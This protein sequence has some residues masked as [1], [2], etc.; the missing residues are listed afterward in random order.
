MRKFLCVFAL[1]CCTGVALASEKPANTNAFLTPTEDKSMVE[2]GTCSF[3]CG[4]NTYSTEAGSL[5]QC[6]CDCAS[7]CGGTCTAS[8]G[9]SSRT[10]TATAS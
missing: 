3:S 5:I 2:S 10:C 6:A 8:D 9:S 4:G 1:L 7:V